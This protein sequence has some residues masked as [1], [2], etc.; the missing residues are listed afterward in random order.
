MASLAPCWR[1]LEDSTAGLVSACPHV[2]SLVWCSWRGWT[3]S[4]AAGFP[5]NQHSK[6]TTRRVLGLFR[7]TLRTHAVLPHSVECR[8]LITLVQIEGGREIRLFLLTGEWLGHVEKLCVEQ[9][10]LLQP[11]LLYSLGKQREMFSE[12]SFWG[13]LVKMLP[14]YSFIFSA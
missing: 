8:L 10:I 13:D 2:A 5:Q 7:H 11:C 14:I 12:T 3:S 1:W 6:R 4:M 9:K